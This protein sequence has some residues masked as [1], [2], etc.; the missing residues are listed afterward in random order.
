MRRMKPQHPE[1]TNAP[2]NDAPTIFLWSIPLVRGANLRGPA[3]NR[4]QAL[5]RG[6]SPAVACQIRGKASL[7]A[8]VRSFGVTPTSIKLIARIANTRGGKMRDLR[9]KT[10]FGS[11]NLPLRTV[12]GPRSGGTGRWKR[13]LATL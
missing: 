13:Q 11:E 2:G 1:D 7:T 4:L 12:F 3:W 5:A 9:P 6:R 10:A 8:I